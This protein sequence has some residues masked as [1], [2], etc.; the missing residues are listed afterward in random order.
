[1][2]G[3]VILTASDR[4]D[5]CGSQANVQGRV[6]A[7]TVLFCAHHYRQFEARLRTMTTTVHDERQRQRQRAVS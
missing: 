1:M 3:S 2:T 6:S 7:G 4:C 5:R